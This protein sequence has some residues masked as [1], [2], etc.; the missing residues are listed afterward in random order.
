MYKLLLVLL[1]STY[2]YSNTTFSEEELSYISNKKVIYISNEFDYEPYDFNREGKPSGY[3]IELLKLIFRDSGLKI[4][5]I[6]KDWDSLLSDVENKKIDLI[7]TIYKTPQREKSLIFSTGYSKVIQSYI[8]R[9]N[10]KDID[11]IKQLFGKKVGISK[12]WSEESFFNK[13]PQI[14]KIYYKNIEE[15]LSALSLGKIDAIVNSDNVAKY[16]IKKYGY[17]TLKVS[18]PV[19]EQFGSRL[20]DHHFASHKDNQI[21]IS[22]INKAYD[23]TSLE[24]IEKLHKKWFGSF[25]INPLIFTNEEHEYILTKKSVNLCIDPNWL[26]YEKIDKNGNHSGM[27]A[28]YFKIFSTLLN[29]EFNLVETKTWSESLNLIKNKKCD[30]VSLITNTK[31]R[32]DIFNFTSTYLKTPIVIATKLDVSFIDSFNKIGNKKIALVK[33]YGFEK[34]LREK[35]TNLNI[36][37]VDNILEGLELVAKGKVFG[38]VDS[39]GTISYTFQTQQTNE[40]KIAGKADI[41]WEL[42][43]GIRKDEPLLLSIMQKA[44]DSVDSEQKQAILNKWIS[45]KYEKGINYSLLWKIFFIFLLVLL[46]FIYKQYLMKKA[47][48]EFSELIDSTMEAILIF[49]DYS[50]I[51]ANKSAIDIFKYKSKE[52]INKAYFFNFISKESKELV[53]QKLKEKTKEP[54]EIL[55]KRA[56]GTKFNALIKE[57]EFKSKKIMIL[58]VIDITHIKQLEAQT[59]QAQMGEMIENIAH[60]WRQPLSTISTISSGIGLNISLNVPPSYEEI[61][62][63]MDKIVETTKYLSNTIE[64]FRNFLREKKELREVILQDRINLVLD[65]VKDSLRNRHIK[66]INKIEETPFKVVTIIGELDQVLINIINNAKDALKEQKIENPWIEIELKKEESIFVITIEDNAK[67]IKEEIMPKIFEPYF[68]TKHKSQGTGLGL[69]MSYKIVTESLKGKIYAQNTENGAKFF[70]ELPYSVV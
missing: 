6:T 19:K 70:I 8:I 11:N 45:I 15:K 44:I 12:G 47:I 29:L 59:K 27:S 7:H 53:G 36:V 30:L 24:E 63:D 48:N 26:P 4:E 31:E 3:S 5:F 67:G 21:L 39:F 2:L 62:K 46:F 66:L 17:G 58:S 61:S 14:E 65:I 22:I 54:F 18:N 10:E 25:S 9:K 64:T 23:N 43:M 55:A 32:K 60:Q 13:Y 34:I 33:D 42:S 37:H 68:T 28:D 1:I 56:D 16:Y 69:H 51:T 49:R 41:E 52:E 40:L 38:Y 50:V 20:D 35:Y 57:V